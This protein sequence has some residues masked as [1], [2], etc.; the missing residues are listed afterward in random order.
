M[1]KPLALARKQTGD[2]GT[3]LEAGRPALREAARKSAGEPSLLLHIGTH[4]TGSTAIQRALR[5]NRAVLL[6]RGIVSQPRCNDALRAMLELGEMD[7]SLCARI[8]GQLAAFRTA[9]ASSLVV[10]N[11]GLCG[12][13]LLGYRNAPDFARRM[14]SCTAGYKVTVLVYIR[15]QD[16]FI[17]S[18]YTQKIHEG[19]TLTFEE[20]LDQISGLVFDWHALLESYAEVF[21]RENIIV[22]RYEKRFMP[23]RESLL[24][25]FFE[26]TGAGHAGLELRQGDAAPNAGY[27]RIA[28]E[29]ARQCNSHLGTEERREMRRVL[30]ASIPKQPHES[31]SHMDGPARASLLARHEASNALVARDYFGDTTGRLFEFLPEEDAGIASA[32]ATGEMLAALVK[33][34]LQ[35][36][37]RRPKSKLGRALVRLGEMMK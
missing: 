26:I 10:S 11:E 5:K 27:S 15:R 14:R 18:L 4:K 24:E 13:P 9:K 17:E 35:T 1:Q 25:D 33:V 19:H 20:F 6:K 34:L 2:I 32:P 29:I 16:E 3:A 36:H 22:R 31:Y 28:A 21:G 8:A 12:D 7:A 30:Q 23:R 37:A